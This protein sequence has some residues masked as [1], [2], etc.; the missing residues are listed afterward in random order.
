MSCTRVAVLLHGL[1]A[2]LGV[3]AL[4]ALAGLGGACTSG[5]KTSCSFH[6]ECPVGQACVGE[7]CV[8]GCRSKA[9]CPAGKSC[10][11]TARC[12][13]E[14]DAGSAGGPGTDGGGG[15]PGLCLPVPDGRVTRAE[16]P[17][18][19]GLGAPFLALA[20]VQEA[21]GAAQPPP[22]GGG[23]AGLLFP[24]L[25]G[26]AAPDGS[27]RRWDL[28]AAA[29]LPGTQ[30]E[31]R[32][33]ALLDPAELPVGERFPG[34]DH[35]VLLPDTPGVLAFFALDDLELRLLG[36][37]DPRGELTLL[38]YD[39]PVTVLRFPVE[40][41]RGWE[42][43]A[44]ARGSFLGA[45][46]R[47]GDRYRTEVRAAGRALLPAGELPVVQ[48]VT[49]LERSFD[50]AGFSQTYSTVDFLGECGGV[51]AKAFGAEGAGAGAGA[52]AAGLPAGV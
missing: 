22:A 39:P 9:D 42:T 37:A 4:A 15:V 19:P 34:A 25:E 11:P 44:T 13:D 41:G 29:H 12:V 27:G 28:S 17:L 52:G 20:P 2:T 21:G 50:S 36:L 3:A 35:A 14:A 5:A 43:T 31:R 38:H 30:A 45:A 23:A 46:V 10:S 8:E 33:V 40:P 18:G 47:V 26:R 24:D 1:P 16:L 6:A 48:L 49:V 51:V 7:R 32:W